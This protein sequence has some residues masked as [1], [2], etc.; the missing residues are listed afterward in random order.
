MR[1][2]YGT[3][4]TYRNFFNYNFISDPIDKIQIGNNSLK[5]KQKQYALHFVFCSTRG[6]PQVII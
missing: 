2:V 1:L 5:K 3:Y 4:G 6:S